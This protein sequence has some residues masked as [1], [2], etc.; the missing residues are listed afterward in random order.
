MSKPLMRMT[1]AALTA[2][3]AS[4]L[5]GCQAGS[6][7]DDDEQ[8]VTIRLWDD[9]AAVAY[10]DAAPGF[11][12]AN[13]GISIEID[14]IPWADYWTTLRNDVA[15]GS[16][17]D[18][19]W[20][21]SSNFIDYAE[22]GALLD[23][24][25]VLGA[26]ASEAWAQT[27]VDQFTWQDGLWGVPQLTDPGIG[28]FYN[29]TLLDEAGV[30][31][32]EVE[33]LV[34]SPDGAGDTLIDVATR[35]T[36]DG[37]GLTPADEAFEPLTLTQFGYN[38]AY[39][40]QAIW[41]NYLA[42]AGAVF[43]DGE[44]LGFDTPEGVAATQYVVDL[45]NEHHVAPSAADTNDNGDFSRD[46]FLQGKLALF[47]TGAYNIAN[48]RDG[49]DFEWGIA[50]LPEGPEGRISLTNG[51]VA[52]ASAT[53]EHPEAQKAVLEWLASVEGASSLGATGAA[54]PAVLDAQQSYFDYWAGEGVDVSPLLDV[55]DNG[56]IEAP[57]GARISE[58]FTAIGPTMKEVFLGR[59]PVAEGLREA[60]EDGNHAGGG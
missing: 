38:A 20:V 41:A 43:Q 42:S 40:F 44:E 27:V 48:I 55:L 32:E 23:I 51:I 19:F 34:W 39:D 31:V 60:Q 4:A 18:I 6:D 14:V 13:D 29:K 8:V 2:V 5:A 9:Q 30:S 50:P 21:N 47:Q 12:S 7:T 24:N 45:I 15:S 17:A 36:K 3:I 22:A 53:S 49:A 52:A 58:A 46:Q 28:V 1:V 33:N 59:I 11:E 56:T 57:H 16:A 26:G 25:E 35:L 54:L 37:A 10:E